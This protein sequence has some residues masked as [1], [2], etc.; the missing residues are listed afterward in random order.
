ME[1]RGEGEQPAHLRLRGS[2]P[3]WCARAEGRPRLAWGGGLSSASRP[4][5]RQRRGGAW[6]ALAGSVSAR[7]LR[8]VAAVRVNRFCPRHGVCADRSSLGINFPMWKLR[9]TEKRELPRSSWG[10]KAGPGLRPRFPSRWYCVHSMWVVG[11]KGT[12]SS[13]T[14]LQPATHLFA[15]QPVNGV[16]R[17]FLCFVFLQHGILRR[18]EERSLLTVLPTSIDSLSFTRCGNWRLCGAAAI[19]L[20]CASSLVYT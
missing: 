15:L 17:G 4:I 16:G 14:V 6:P 20:H 18:N 2:V 5:Q 13:F 3:S 10:L 7:G 1:G 8:R 11:S 9:H 12:F 19:F